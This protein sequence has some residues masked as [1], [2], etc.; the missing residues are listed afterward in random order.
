M[1]KNENRVPNVDLDLINQHLIGT[2]RDFNNTVDVAKCLVDGKENVTI[3][4]RKEAVKDERQE[5]PARAHAF[6]TLEDFI[7]Y[8]SA[9][10]GDAS[11][12]LLRWVRGEWLIT[13]T[14]DEAQEGGLER[15]VYE[16]KIH[17][18]IA[19][20]LEVDMSAKQ[21]YIFLIENKSVIRV[22]TATELMASFKQIKISKKLTLAAG[23]G[24]ECKNGFMTET[25]IMGQPALSIPIPLP[26]L[27]DIECPLFMD[28]QDQTYQL[29]CVLSEEN[30]EACV[31]L[32]FP[33]TQ[34][35]FNKLQETVDRL[36][37][38]MP[39]V[40][41]GCGTVN[42]EAWQYRRKEL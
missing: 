23:Q 37:E 7:Q 28:S 35:Y 21:F 34:A 25:S 41:V 3:T 31:K 16:P 13:M 19:P 9:N 15:I 12:A 17:P 26:E 40:T 42:Y 33:K 5:S 20:W 38:A 30:D 10:R 14:L 8:A 1:S 18:L 39:N 4:L 22:P 29:D 2:T 24:N 32:I 11:I 27:I 6:N 36:K